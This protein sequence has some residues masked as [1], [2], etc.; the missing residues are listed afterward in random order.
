MIHR[1]TIDAFPASPLGVAVLAGLAEDPAL[2]HSRVRIQN[3]GMAAAMARYGSEHTPQVVMVE[4]EESGDDLLTHLDQLAD[5]CEA[6]TRVIVLGRDNDIHLYRTLMARGVSEYLPLPATSAEAVEAVTGL[7]ADPQAAPKGKV[8]AF[9]GVRGGSGSSTLAQ[10]VAFCLGQSLREKVLYL[11][12]DAAFGTSGL[13]FDLEARQSAAEALA[14]PDR[15]DPVMLERC[16]TDYDDNL[17]VLAA[18]GDPRTAAR[19]DVDGVDRLLDTAAQL[20]AMVVVDLPRLW[21]DWTAQVLYSAAEVVLVSAPD[22]ASLRDCKCMLEILGQRRGPARAPKLVL[23]RVEA[24][25]RT[26]LDAKVFADTLGLPPSL[27]IPFDAPSFG[28]AANSGRMLPEAAAAS[29]V[30]QSMRQLAALLAGKP[31]PA[32]GRD[33]RRHLVSWLKG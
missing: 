11:D 28:E 21:T 10:N 24:A 23:N 4:A 32:T 9:W 7:F 12:L 2:A 26:Q 29:P 33:W 30:A 15:M 19:L 18:P 5:V 17:R 14:H 1:L 27:S 8:V 20:G 25:R 22:L 3:G 31:L 6:T 16:L 13:A